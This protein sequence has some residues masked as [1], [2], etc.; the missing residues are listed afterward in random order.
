MWV[1]RYQLSRLAFCRV[2]IFRPVEKQYNITTAPTCRGRSSKDTAIK[3]DD[4]N[5]RRR[6]ALFFSSFPSPGGLITYRTSCSTIHTHHCRN[7]TCANRFDTSRR[8]ETRYFFRFVVECLVL[9]CDPHSL[10]NIGPRFFVASRFRRYFR[11]NYYSIDALY[12][13]AWLGKLQTFRWGGGDSNCKMLL[14]WNI[15]HKIRIYIMYLIYNIIVD[16]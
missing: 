9:F 5:R 6:R 2:H 11:I 4:R 8:G 13:W 14:F 3:T 15:L 12:R 16:W 7:M 1:G 10:S